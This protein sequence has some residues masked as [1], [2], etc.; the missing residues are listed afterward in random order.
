M[1]YVF[2]GLIIAFAIVMGAVR[3][4]LGW[5]LPRDVMARVDMAVDRGFKA[6]LQIVVVLIGG[7]IL[8]LVWIVFAGK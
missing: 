1:L 4:V 2:L 6:V 8:V 5:V 7:G 3:I